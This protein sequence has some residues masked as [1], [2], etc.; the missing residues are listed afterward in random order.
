MK[1]KTRKRIIIF[2]IALLVVGA[3]SYIYLRYRKLHDLEPLLT[4]KLQKIVKEGTKGL[5]NLKLDK[6]NVDPFNSRILLLNVKLVVDS[7][8]LNEMIQQ[9]KAP[10][11]IYN[12][13]LKTLGIDGLSGWDILTKKEINLDVLFIKNPEIKIYHTIRNVDTIVKKDT[14]TFYQH[15]AKELGKVNIKKLVVDNVTFT[16]NNLTPPNKIT[17]F[18]NVSMLFTDIQIDSTTQYDSSRFLYAKNADISLH[19]YQVRTADSLYFLNIDSIA[20]SASA[21]TML[22]QKFAV[23]PRYKREEFE[24]KLSNIKD[25]YELSIEKIQ[26]KKIDWWNLATENGF[27]ADEVELS[28][29]KFNDYCDRS[30]PEAPSKLGKYPQQSLMSLPFPFQIVQ[31]KINNFDISYEELNPNTQKSGT[32]YFKDVSGTIENMTNMADVIK[33]NQWMNAKANCTFMNNTP[34]NADFK[35]NLAKAKEGVF[36]VDA[37]MGKINETVLNPITKPL[38]LVEIDNADVKNLK[39]HVEGDNYKASAEITFLYDNLKITALKKDEDAQSKTKK[40]KFLSFLANSLILQKSNPSAN[41][42]ITTVNSFYQRDVHKSFFNLIFKVILKGI[43][44][45]MGISI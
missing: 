5:Y 22:F 23:V 30:L 44:D 3:G 28:N 40:R 45:T 9:Q 4:A 1:S 18:Q 2:L 43:L 12:I 14:A 34:I 33:A 16:Y 38:A 29:G 25:R 6:L 15:I 27:A 37:T 32:L 17:V 35:F 41:G 31:M 11:D 42:K 36:I 7:S 26:F 20:I 39:A 10:N 8:V 24:K 21:R 13:S 19:N